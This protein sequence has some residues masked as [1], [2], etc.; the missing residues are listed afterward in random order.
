MYVTNILNTEVNYNSLFSSKT[1][2]FDKR[3]DEKNNY[4]CLFKIYLY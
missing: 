1:L 4:L 2:R 3:N